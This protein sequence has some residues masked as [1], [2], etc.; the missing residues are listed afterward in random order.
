MADMTC[1]MNQDEILKEGNGLAFV[2]LINSK[3]YSDIANSTWSDYQEWH[4]YWN[5]YM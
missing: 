2:K 4:D 5:Q 1:L 3:D